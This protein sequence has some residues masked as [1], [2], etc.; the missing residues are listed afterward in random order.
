M[1]G[2]SILSC[3]NLRKNY[4]NGWLKDPTLALKGINLDVPRG[5]VYG[6]LGPNGAGKTTFVKIMLGLVGATGGKADL[7][8]HP[9][10][11]REILQNVGYL[12]EDRQ[13]PPHLTGKQTVE[14]YGKLNEIP[15]SKR[16]ERGERLLKKFGIW[17]A[18]DEQV[19]TY[20]K[21]MK[22]RLGL[23]QALVNDPEILFLDEPAS[24]VDPVGRKMIRGFLDEL[25]SEEG[26]TVFINSHIL[27]ELELICDRVAILKEGELVHESTMEEL[28]E[29]EV[30]YQVRLASSLPAP[31]KNQIQERWKWKE[32]PEV[33]HGF[34]VVVQNEEEIDDLLELLWGNVKIRELQ[35][36]TQSL[37]DYF[38]DVV[39]DELE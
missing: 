39:T 12:P 2:N 32:N 25:V 6:L 35:K 30:R 7:L 11:S 28:Q 13:F 10:P 34:E 3:E 38:I 29:Q 20:S 9:V 18:S 31:L 26:K 24:G 14:Y 17:E 36:I 22:Q 1:S 19:R 15:H 5:F 23:A 16:S 33:E 4:S 37:E 8:G 21:G 27:T